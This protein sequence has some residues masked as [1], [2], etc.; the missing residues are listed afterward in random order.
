MRGGSNTQLLRPPQPGS[1]TTAAPNGTSTTCEDYPPND[2]LRY[3]ALRQFWEPCLAGL[4]YER[5]PSGPEPSHDKAN[6]LR[7]KASCTFP[8]KALQH[9][10]DRP[11]ILPHLRSA[12]DC[13]CNT[14]FL[15]HIHFGAEQDVVGTGTQTFAP[16]TDVPPA[17]A[18]HLSLRTQ[19]Q[20][21]F[22]HTFEDNGVPHVPGLEF[23]DFDEE[24]NEL[25]D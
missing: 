23:Y 17:P 5:P 19:A 6:R 12:D 20:E 11:Y 7:G 13:W 9:Q 22:D 18:A 1:A 8:D 21:P 16:I 25:Y 2:S 10:G 15:C 4:A 3:P 24:D 14:D